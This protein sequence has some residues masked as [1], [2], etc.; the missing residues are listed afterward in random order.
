[1]RHFFQTLLQW[2]SNNYYIFCVH[3]FNLIMHA[4][5]MLDIVV[6]GLLGSK[7]I[8]STLSHK[9]HIFR[10]MISKCV[11]WFSLQLLSGTFLV[12]RR[13][14]GDTIKNIYW[15]PVVLYR[16]FPTF[17]RKRRDFRKTFT[18]HKMCVLIFSTTFVWNISR[19]KKNRGRY[20]QKYILVACLAVQGFSH[21]IS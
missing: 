10:K 19:S 7:L 2:K 1:M 4:M 5:V 14:G 21:I 15:W 20:D 18:K 8:F 9:K 12:L 11:F 3:V 17:S 16:V 13:T 6:C